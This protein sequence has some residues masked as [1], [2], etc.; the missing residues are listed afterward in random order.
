MSKWYKVQAVK[1]ITVVVEVEDHEDVYAA[2]DVANREHGPF[3]ESKA[4]EIPPNEVENIIRHADEV[5]RL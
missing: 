1:Y 3:D 4:E 2:Y 5:E